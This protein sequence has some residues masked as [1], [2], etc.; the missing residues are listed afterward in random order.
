[1][2]LI[3][4]RRLKVTRGEE[5]KFEDKIRGWVS[6]QSNQLDDKVLLKG[7]GMPTYH[8]ANVVDDY[9]MKITDVIRGEEWLPSTPTHVLLYQSFG[10]IESMPKFSHLPLILK[11]N[12]KGKLSKRDGDKLGIPVFPLDESKSSLT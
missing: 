6:F 4:S 9:L 8:L 3:A 12:G 10:W 1:M 11:P 2:A 7:D 5:I